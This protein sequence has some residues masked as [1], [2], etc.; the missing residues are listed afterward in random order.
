MDV[1]RQ[2]SEAVLP[3]DDE[4]VA[5]VDQVAINLSDGEEEK[6][7][8]DPQS[9]PGM[10]TPEEANGNNQVL[11]CAMPKMVAATPGGQSGFNE[12]ETGFSSPEV[13]RIAKRKSNKADELASTDGKRFSAG[14]I[15]TESKFRL[16]KM[17]GAD[18]KMNYQS[19]HPAMSKSMKGD[20][21]LL[22]GEEEKVAFGSQNDQK[23]GNLSRY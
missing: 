3:E 15:T 22:A 8:V 16:D 20:N 4:S 19:A 5:G 18:D 21:A 9:N 23:F 11:S 17:N 2:E 6:E 13:D 7:G 14:G 10:P 12:E 1:L